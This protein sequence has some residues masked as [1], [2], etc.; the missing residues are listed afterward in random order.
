MTKTEYLE[1]LS[2]H[3][4]KLPQA[5]YQEAMAYFTEYFDEA[6]PDQEATLIKELGSP[7]EAA[8]DIIHNILGESITS[9]QK[10]SQKRSSA[11]LLGIAILAIL[12]APMGILIFITLLGMLLTALAVLVTG[13]ILAIILIAVG[14]FY[15]F[16]SFS[17]L[18]QVSLPAAGLGFGGGLAALGIG[19]LGVFIVIELT[20]LCS[21]LILVIAH[22]VT[23][24]GKTV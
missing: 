22:K 15:L 1:A 11:Q 6:G 12:A 23:K 4:R 16:D 13:A 14:G 17:L 3:L 7:Q 19:L 2:H 21:Y 5:D 24:K 20:R 10:A 9:K 8:K 18:N